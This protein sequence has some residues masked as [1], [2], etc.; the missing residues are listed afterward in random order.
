MCTII[1]SAKGSHNIALSPFL[2]G[3]DELS[4]IMVSHHISY[5]IGSYHEPPFHI[6]HCITHR[7]NNIFIYVPGT[8][9][10]VSY[11]IPGILYKVTRYH[12]WTRPGIIL[13]DQD[14]INQSYFGSST[15]VYQIKCLSNNNIIVWLIFPLQP[16][17]RK[18][19]SYLL[20]PGKNTKQKKH[21]QTPSHNASPI[22]TQP[23][24]RRLNKHMMEAL[25]G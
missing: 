21:H 8:R 10:I 1:N 6:S 24:R 2:Y 19:N 14:N 17:V 5:N 23:N 25:L 16:A 18:T 4:S 3:D 9:Y 20:A 22:S 11:H 13:G 7:K 12:T 15:A